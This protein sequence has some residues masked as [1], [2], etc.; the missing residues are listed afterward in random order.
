MENKA[1]LSVELC[2]RPRT[3][4]TN[5]VELKK[6]DLEF[7]KFGPDCDH[8]F[9]GEVVE[10]RIRLKNNSEL[11]FRGVDFRD[12]LGDDFRYVPLSF[13]VN[14]RPALAHIHQGEVRF[15]FPIIRAHSEH[16]IRFRVR[17]GRDEGARPPLWTP[18]WVRT[19]GE[20]EI[21]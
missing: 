21:A 12:P 20:T 13:R 14:G 7:E 17:V 10:F 2:G 8:V 3:L 6:V 18:P 5:T 19:E 11:D 16:E 15:R 4:E 1:F 9:M